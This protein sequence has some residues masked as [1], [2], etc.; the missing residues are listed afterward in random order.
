LPVTAAINIAHDKTER[1]VDRKLKA[2]HVPHDT[3][4]DLVTLEGELRLHNY[5]K[6]P[7]EIVISNSVPGKPISAGDEGRIQTD[8]TKLKIDERAGTVAWR[9]KLEPDE[10]RALD[11]RYERYVPSR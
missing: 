11:Y 8:P 10:R 4:F 3:Y 9:V 7:V 1:E 2:H 6:R 5:E